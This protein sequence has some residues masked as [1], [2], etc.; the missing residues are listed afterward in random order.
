ML[1]AM[2]DSPTVFV[3]GLTAT[4]LAVARDVAPHGWRVVGV[5]ADRTRPGC[6]SRHVQE[7]PNLSRLPLGLALVDALLDAAAKLPVPPIVVPAADDAVQWCITHRKTLQPRVVL[8]QGLTP[9]RA[10]VLLDKSAFGQRCAELGLDVPLTVQP[11]SM[12]DVHAFVAQAGLPCI[13]KPR[14]GHLWRQKLRGQK[15]LVPNTLAE[16]EK[17]LTDVIGDISAVVLQELVPG[18]ES[19]LLVGAVLSAETGGVRTVVTGRKLRQ[20]PR[21]FGSGSLVRT[22]NLP[23]VAQLSASIIERLDYRGLC[24][25]EFKL[26]PRSGRL[27]LIE[28]NPRPTLWYDLCRAAGSSLIWSHVQELAGLSADVPARQQDGVTWRYLVRDALALAGAGP[29][30]L[31]DSLRK[32]ARVDTDAVFAWDDPLSGAASLGHAAVQAISH[33]KP[34]HK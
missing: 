29:S 19:N 23:D 8:S 13:V 5:D 24:G 6:Y 10:G 26:D 18:P 17:A 7:L 1:V 16:L 22:E 14:A 15:L 3:L 28:I 4:G 11:S 12:A 33:L 2:A 32:D 30:A 21:N 34:G 20:F 27:R 25:T 31:L 9:E